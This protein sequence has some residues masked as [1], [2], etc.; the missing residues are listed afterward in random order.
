MP[1]DGQVID[2]K[3]EGG[4]LTPTPPASAFDTEVHIQDLTNVSGGG[5]GT[6]GTWHVNLT[7]EPFQMF[8]S[9]DPAQLPQHVND[10]RP[11]N[12]CV[13]QGDLVVLNTEG[14]YEPG[15]YSN[16]VPLQAFASVPNAVTGFFRG[17]LQTMNGANVML[18]QLAPP[19]STQP[20]AMLLMQVQLASAAN[21]V[22]PCRGVLGLDTA[23][24]NSQVPGQPGGGPDGSL[25]PG[26]YGVRH[27]GTFVASL[28][29]KKPVGQSCT[30]SG[31][32][33]F[34]GAIANHAVRSRSAKRKRT[35][36]ISL[37]TGSFNI[38]GH[39]TGKFTIRLTKRGVQLI[40]KHNRRLNVTLV[41]KFSSGAVVSQPITLKL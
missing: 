39:T 15:T 1:T 34:G 25:R 14:G 37:G 28:Y 11:T 35:G 16:G 3:V 38:P 18:S 22:G 12:L 13:H 23:G 40:R 9:A 8:A 24:A 29:C 5:D 30:G 31:T 6:P 33:T 26:T 27:D 41:V 7:S 20:N 19:D 17:H 36:P 4:F 10:F 32:P 2:V 21:V